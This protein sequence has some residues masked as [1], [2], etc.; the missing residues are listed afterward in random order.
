VSVSLLQLASA[1]PPFSTAGGVGTIVVTLSPTV[2]TTVQL[3]SDAVAFRMTVTEPDGDLVDPGLADTVEVVIRG[4]DGGLTAEG[5]DIVSAADGLLEWTTPAGYFPTGGR[6]KVQAR[7]TYPDGTVYY[8]PPFT[9]RV[10]AN[11]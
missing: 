7:L 2:T 1:L 5:A 6:W 4:P 9:V 11:V 10:K 3:G 8:S